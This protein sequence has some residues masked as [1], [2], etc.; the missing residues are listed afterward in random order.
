LP[1]VIAARGPTTPSAP[2]SSLRYRPDVEGLRAL[3]V[4]GVLLFHAGWPFVLGGYVGVDVF[5]VI[6][7]FLMTGLILKE[8]TRTGRFSFGAFYARR[9]RRILPAATVVLAVSA[10]LSLWLLPW[11]EWSRTGWD[12]GSAGLFVS[13]FRF[14]F[15][16]TDYLNA[17]LGASPVLNYWSLSVEEQFYLVWPLLLVAAL[18]LG[19][20]RIATGLLGLTAVASFLLSL[21][22]T[23]T[24]QP[25][26]FFMMPARAWEFALGGLVAIALARRR[27]IP[28][29]AALWLGWLGAGLIVATMLLLTRAT[30][31]P[32]WVVLLPVMGTAAIIWS[33]ASSAGRGSVGSVLSTGPMRAVGRVSYSWY[34]WHFPLLVILPIGLDLEPS[35]WTGTVIVALAWLPAYATYRLVETPIRTAGGA[36]RTGRAAAIILAGCVGLAIAVAAALLLWP[37]P[38]LTLQPEQARGATAATVPA[39]AASLTPGVSEARDDLPAIYDDG[40]HGDVTDTRVSDCT[41]GVKNSGTSVVLLG[42]S[43]AAQWQPPLAALAEERG[44]TLHSWTKSSCAPGSGSSLLPDPWSR[45]YEECDQWLNDVVKELKDL[46]PALVIASGWQPTQLLMDGQQAT[47]RAAGEQYRQSL[48]KDVAAIQDIGVPLV[49]LQDTPW[50][51]KDVPTCLSKRNNAE[52]CNARLAD[53]EASPEAAAV[54][55][56]SGVPTIDLTGAICGAE[57]CEAIRG[58]RIVW[59]DEHH[60]TASYAEALL[61]LLAADLSETGLLPASTP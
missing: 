11:V 37:R 1:E 59:R 31:F 27:L 56:S 28:A 9:V 3:A 42:D 22:W 30:L 53:V 54:M 2:A 34:L 52:A 25:Y 16:A 12:I 6:S 26:A 5:F 10:G 8:R 21:Q 32:G 40:C 51:G 33:G 35:V 50:Q 44:W 29:R 46:R 18:A 47:G 61:P 38:E 15:E 45:P 19:R 39:P 24:A 36:M 14:A 4:G 13:N 43:H 23:A 48:S 60:L 20:V 55:E 57:E 7:G 41:Y 17:E 58:N 49:W